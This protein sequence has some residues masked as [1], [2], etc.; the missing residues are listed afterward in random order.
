MRY[1]YALGFMF[2]SSL[3][4]ALAQFCSPDLVTN[5]GF[6]ATPVYVSSS[7]CQV[8]IPNWNSYYLSGSAEV[9]V[10]PTNFPIAGSTPDSWDAD[11]I[12]NNRYWRSF[13][14]A[15]G[16]VAN[17]GLFQTLGTPLA[18]NKRHVLRLHYTG[19]APSVLG[20][21]I[22]VE[23]R[24]STVPITCPNV[25][26]VLL[27]SETLLLTNMNDPAFQWHTLT[28]AFTPTANLPYLQVNL[29]YNFVK[30][31]S[32][33][34]FVD[35]IEVVQDDCPYD[36][37]NDGIVG[38]GDLLILIG[39]YGSTTDAIANLCE[40]GADINNDGIVNATDVELFNAQFGAN[41]NQIK[42][43]APAPEAAPVVARELM[44]Y[45]NPAAGTTTFTFADGTAIQR[46]EVYGADGRS[47]MQHLPASP[48]T[49]TTVDLGSLPAGLYLATCFTD[50]GASYVRVV[51]E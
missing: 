7:G 18:A 27:G 41:C 50:D 22:T 21:S 46:L 43:L 25:A 31:S 35:D 16:A 44:A 2:L 5:G 26:P 10:R 32:A 47:V 23:V 49:Q 20:T 14:I 17:R 3:G 38:V 39:H 34:V 9:L 37:N 6:E 29:K 40:V 36:L 28:A 51:K 19:Y 30:N 8:L 12:N 4:P 1:Y 11:P 15:T 24:G 33:R 48:E 45:P 13:Q 42:G